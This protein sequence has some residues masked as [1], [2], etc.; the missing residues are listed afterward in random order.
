MGFAAVILAASAALLGAGPVAGDTRPVNISSSWYLPDMDSSVFLRH[1]REKVTWPEAESI[2]RQHHGTLATVEGS[3]DFD[4]TRSYL[5]REGAGA[6][7]SVWIGLRRARPG[8]DFVWINSHPMGMEGGYWL[9]SPPSHSSPPLCV[10]LDPSADFRW[11][12]KGCGPESTA[13]FLCQLPVPLWVGRGEGGCLP[14]LPPSSAPPMSWLTIMYLPEQGALD[15]TADCG[16]KGQRQLACKKG[17]TTGE[18]L[19]WRLSCTEDLRLHLDDH[20]MRQRRGR[21]QTHAPPTRHRRDLTGTS[22]TTTQASSPSVMPLEAQSAPLPSPVPTNPHGTTL[23]PS[24]VDSAPSSTEHHDSGN[25]TMEISST[26]LSSSEVSYPSSSPPSSSMSS[27]AFVTSMANATSQSPELHLPTSRPTPTHNLTVS[28]T[29]VISPASSEEND[30]MEVIGQELSKTSNSQSVGDEV[31]SISNVSPNNPV[32][33]ESLDPQSK[34]GSQSIS[35][36]VLYIEPTATN[37]PADPTSTNLPTK[38]S[39]VSFTPKSPPNLEDATSTSMSASTTTQSLNPE[40][41]QASTLQH[42]TGTERTTVSP[43]L[44]TDSPSPTTASMLPLKDLPE[45]SKAPQ[46]ASSNPES[47]HMSLLP[48]PTTSETTTSQSPSTEALSQST[49]SPTFTTE[50]SS[51]PYIPDTRVE[52]LKEYTS[53]GM[54]NSPP[55]DIRITAVAGDELANQVEPTIQNPDDKD[56]LKDA[57]DKTENEILKQ[58]DDSGFQWIKI[59]S[60]KDVSYQ[61][62]QEKVIQSTEVQDKEESTLTLVPMPDGTTVDQKS[63]SSATSA[64]KNDA[65]T[66][67][68]EL[69]GEWTEVGTLD[70]V[71][72]RFLEERDEVD[73]D[74]SS[75]PPRPNRSRKLTRPQG[76]SFY[77]YFLSRVLG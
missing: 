1:F 75:P 55:R 62:S 61:S 67:H 11:R 49:E 33:I 29:V 38:S 47:Q 66:G 18:E 58:D 74:L 23:P 14:S 10:A 48:S 42:V 19:G 4:A 30:T 77:T 76:R 39:S 31:F 37:P 72:E 69:D 22:M 21:P 56:S 5:L 6:S 53:S 64:S 24:P 41:F 35:I 13:T 17:T 54:K 32:K 28:L 46:T 57:Q 34:S 9:E 8:G 73:S 50:S 20:G 36:D 70:P 15:L 59:G 7:G 25:G 26:P 71:S 68:V 16:P 63:T 65:R 44:Q 3:R 2:C 43:I 12:A 60:D 52:V 27:S 45:T 40:T 51:V